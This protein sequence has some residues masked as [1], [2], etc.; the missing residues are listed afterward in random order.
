MGRGQTRAAGGQR[1]K[2]HMPVGGGGGAVKARDRFGNNITAIWDGL[3]KS[4]VTE[5]SMPRRLE[6]HNHT[7]KLNSEY[8]AAQGAAAP[9]S[10]ANIR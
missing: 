10:S 8:A 2:K 7:T 1:G 9:N 6:G 4:V 3:L 5:H